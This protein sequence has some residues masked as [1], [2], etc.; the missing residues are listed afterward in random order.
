M[1]KTLMTTMAAGAVFGAGVVATQG[2]QAHA[3]AKSDVQSA[4]NRVDAAKAKVDEL[5]KGKDV[6]EVQGG[7]P[8]DLQKQLTDAQNNVNNAQ[9]TLD[10]TAGYLQYYQNQKASLQQ[11]LDEATSASNALSTTDP[12]YQQSRVAYYTAKYAVQDNDAQIQNATGWVKSYTI[13]LQQAKDKLATIQ[14]QTNSYGAKT[15]TVKK[16]DQA[17][18][19]AAKKEYKAAVKALDEAKAKAD[20]PAKTV[21]YDVPAV[22]KHNEFT[23]TVEAKKAEVK[24]EAAKRAAK[25]EAKKHE[26]KKHVAKKA[27]KKAKKHVIKKIVKKAKHLFS[28]RIKAKKVYAYK[29]IALH[30]S[31][32]KV[33]KKGT[34]LYVYKIVKKGNKQ[35]YK[36]AGNRVITANKHYVVKV[37]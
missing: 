26:A 17:A 35:F 23:K 31:G 32:R 28:V 9:K 4:Q 14:N 29:T 16:V 20:A 33:E 36:I 34:K 24:H 6:T 1:N 18:L 12:A 22:G 3:D 37:K 30:K 21:T 11:K 25:H 10:D 5:S 15:V 19:D 2:T 8:A 13:Q 7:I 27:T